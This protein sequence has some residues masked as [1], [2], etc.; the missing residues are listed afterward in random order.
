[1]SSTKSTLASGS[2]SL[3]IFFLR[4]YFKRY[5]GSIPDVVCVKTETEPAGAVVVSAIFL[6]P[7]L[8]VRSLIS[9]SASHIL[10]RYS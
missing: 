9:G 10:S 6:L 7:Y 5:A 4:V 8:C 3:F 1:M 2:A